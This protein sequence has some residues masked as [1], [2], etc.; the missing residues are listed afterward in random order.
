MIGTLRREL[1]DRILIVN[2]RHLRQILTA[3]L[4]HF[5]TAR[6]SPSAGATR[7]DPG[8]DPT[9][10]PDQ[11][12]WSPDSPQTDPRRTYQ[13]VPHRSMIEHEHRN[14]LVKP[15]ILYSSPTGCLD[16]RG[17]GLRRTAARYPAR[18]R[19]RRPRGRKA[20]N[21]PT[22]RRQR[23]DQPPRRQR[24]VVVGVA[25]VQHHHLVVTSP[26]GESLVHPAG[27]RRLAGSPADRSPALRDGSVPAPPGTAR[28]PSRNR[29][30]RAPTPPRKSCRAPTTRNGAA[31]SDLNPG[32]SDVTPRVI[33][34]PTDLGRSILLLVIA[35]R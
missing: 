25:L 33:H 35:T 9:P 15:E 10:T 8:R 21:A 14:L 29:R 3:Y 24:R 16:I 20:A 1:L 22:A 31:Q 28:P 12:G 19:P 17:D 6:P 30:T 23:G 32:W 11:P 5:N 2:E 27:Q 26:G 4:H 7:T 34:P 13:R 18:A